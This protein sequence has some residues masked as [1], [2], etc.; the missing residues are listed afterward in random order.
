MDPAPLLALQL[1]LALVL[2][3]AAWHKLRDLAAFR[4]ALEGYGLLP[5]A[6][7]AAGAVLAPA[8]EAFAAAALGVAPAAGALAA[9]ALLALYTAAISWNL[10]RGRRGIDC[11]CAGPALRQPLSGS[12]VA[13]NLVLCAA[14]LACAAP[15][16]GRALVWVDALSIAGGVAVLTAL[17]AA[18]NG[19]IAQAPRLAP[20]RSQP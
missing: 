5:L 9:G 16:S 14:A 4:A 10:W 6:A 18:S 13:R 17:Y 11:G 12:L 20:L 2:A 3:T 19:L 7:L 15:P 8:A 1:A